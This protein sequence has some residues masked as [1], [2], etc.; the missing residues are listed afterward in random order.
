MFKKFLPKETGFFD[1]FEQIS[2]LSTEACKELLALTAPGAVSVS[3]GTLTKSRSSPAI[4][5]RTTALAPE[6]GLIA[7]S[8]PLKF[9]LGCHEL[10]YYITEVLFW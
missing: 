1:Y 4:T 5:L 6:I 10:S 9:Y 3:G 2:V 8:D 7:R